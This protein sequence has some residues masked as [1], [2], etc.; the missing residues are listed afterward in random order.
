LGTYLADQIPPGSLVYWQGG[1]S[2]APLLYI[3]DVQVFAPQLNQDYSFHLSGESEALYK[4]GFW[5]RE[6]AEQWLAEADYALVVTRYYKDWVKET[7]QDTEK[8]ELQ[9]I[10]PPTVLCE[11]DAVIRVFRRIP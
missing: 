11:P 7:L 10:A 4:Y 6:L 2:P 8:Y 9:G 1:L 3:P 5:N